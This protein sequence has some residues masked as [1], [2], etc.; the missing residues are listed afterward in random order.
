MAGASCE[1]GAGGT[2]GV[3]AIVAVEQVWRPLRAAGWQGWVD[4]PD[5][6]T[7][8][9]GGP[10]LVRGWVASGPGGAPPP[11]HVEVRR[12]DGSVLVRVPRTADR[13]DVGAAIPGA[14]DRCGYHVELDLHGAGDTVL[15][16]AGDAVLAR[17]HVR[18]LAGPEGSDGSQRGEDVVLAGLLPPDAPRWVVDVGAHD[19]A[20]LSNSAP[21]LDAGW[22]G[23]LVEPAPVP[24][25]RLAARY[26]DR[27]TARCVQAACSDHEGA[28]P[29]FLGRDDDGGTNATLCTDDNAWFAETRSARSVEVRVTTL[30][31]LCREHGVPTAFGLLLV[32][33]EGMDLEV[34]RGLDPSPHRPMVVCTERYLHRP[35]KESAKAELLSSWGLVH[36]ATVGWNDLWVRPGLG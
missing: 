36:H 35:D 16:T 21:F 32:D 11:T 31:A 15:V 10:V 27:P 12:A 5:P 17:L 8:V 4:Q 23:L 3:P 25:A 19:G 20:H 14:G 6:G 34:L 26:R 22:E 9:D 2:V 18:D 30:A 28:A 13:P 24:F 33:A 1:G 29:L 7:R